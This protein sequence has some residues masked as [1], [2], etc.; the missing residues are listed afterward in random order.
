MNLSREIIQS[1]NCEYQ[2]NIYN[3]H[4]A[5]FFDRLIGF[6]IELRKVMI[7]FI[8]YRTRY[9]NIMFYSIDASLVRC[10]CG[11]VRKTL[12]RLL[13]SSKVSIPL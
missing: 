2:P 9:I 1:E 5:L 6:P 8:L 10:D 11:F 13:I 7:R 3:V 12:Q 4:N